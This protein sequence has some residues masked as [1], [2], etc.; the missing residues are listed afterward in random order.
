MYQ[1]GADSFNKIIVSHYN[2][3]LPEI[4]CSLKKIIGKQAWHK[5]FLI[6]FCVSLCITCPFVKSLWKEEST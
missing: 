2:S 5:Y 3:V 4:V 6:N 1:V